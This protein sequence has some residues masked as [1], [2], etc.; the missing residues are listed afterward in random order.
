MSAFP[1]AAA[2]V[3]GRTDDLVH[4]Q[5]FRADRRAGDI[6]NSINRAHFMEVD[7]LD[8]GV[9]NLGLRRS[10]GLKNPDGALLG[11]L[12]DSSRIDDLPDLL[13]AALMRMRVRMRIL[14]ILGIRMP[15]TMLMIAVRLIV[16]M[17]LMQVV[18]IVRRMLVIVRVMIVTVLITIAV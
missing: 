9:V 4:A 3:Q 2:P 12:A 10:L 11:G 5:G 7:L 8:V 1:H 16:R 13:Q 15:A 6:H 18:M 14:M 17:P